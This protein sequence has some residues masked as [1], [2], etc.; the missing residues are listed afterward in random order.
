MYKHNS[1]F[2]YFSVHSAAALR[3]WVNTQVLSPSQHRNT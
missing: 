3:N 2:M 1:D